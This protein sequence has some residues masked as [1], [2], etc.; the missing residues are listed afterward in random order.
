MEGSCGWVALK[1]YSLLEKDEQWETPMEWAP[2]RV[3]IS[4]TDSPF[5]AKLSLS[6]S[7]LKLGG[8][9]L[10]GTSDSND[11]LPSPAFS[12]PA[13]PPPTSRGGRK[14]TSTLFGLVSPALSPPAL[15]LAV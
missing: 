7:A 5:L 12:G 14:S 10:P 4:S 9:I 15:L 2:E 11:T 1:P 8:G 13:P 6:C 3:T